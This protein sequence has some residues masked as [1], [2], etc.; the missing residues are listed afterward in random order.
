MFSFLP[1]V[2]SWRLGLL[3]SICALGF[4]GISATQANA[5][6]INTDAC[7]ENALT[8]PFSPWGDSNDYELAPDGNFETPLSGWS[9]SGGAGRVSGGASFSSPG[10]SS[11]Y[12]LSVPAGASAETPSSCVDAAYP[13]FRFVTDSASGATMLVEVVYPTLLGNLALPIQVLLVPSGWQ[14][15]PSALTVSLVGALLKDGTTPM[16]IRFV[17][18]TGS[19]RVD[20]VYIDPRMV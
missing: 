13:T 19:A 2:R 3:G 4:V 14:P 11:S 18:L 8:Q 16:S 15:T 17:T 5:A 6:L 20:D 12:S 1:H 9:V 7:N 10:L